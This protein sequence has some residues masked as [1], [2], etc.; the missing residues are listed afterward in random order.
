MVP[1][2]NFPGGGPVVKIFAFQCRGAGLIPG[3]G[4]KIPYATQ[5][6][7]QNMKQKHYCNKSNKEFKKMVH[8]KKL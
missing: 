5:S 1:K 6:K 4:A 3:Q 8:I 7:N 2:R